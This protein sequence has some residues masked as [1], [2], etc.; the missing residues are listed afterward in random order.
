[1]TGKK[2]IVWGMVLLAFCT[3]KL[4]AQSSD[5]W[6][7][8]PNLFTGTDSEKIAQAL[9]AAENNGGVIRIP[10]RAA[11]A[12]SDR[13]FWLLDEAV[14]LPSDTTLILENCVLKLSD[15][16]RD[17]FIRTA[18]AG[19]GIENPEPVHNIHITGIGSV[20]LIG[21]DHPRSTGDSGKV[22]GQRSYGTDA[23]KE[24]ESQKGDWRNIGILLANVDNF[25]IENL[26]LRQTHCWGISIERGTNG[27]IRGLTFDSSENRTID[28]ATVKTLNQD[29][30]D[31]RKGCRNIVIENIR[32][33]TGDDLVALTAI[34]IDKRPG[35][36]L[37]STEV[38]PTD[39]D[40]DNDI[41]YVTIK[42]VVGYAAGG[43][44]IV[45]LLNASG[46]KIHH[47]VIDTVVDTSPEDVIDRATVRIGDANPS[48]GGVT[49]LGDT[50]GILITNVESRSAQAVLIAGSLTDSIITNVINYNPAVTG[51]G[52]ESGEENVRNVQ[53]APFINAGQN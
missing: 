21:A 42:N 5:G 9:A 6:N 48:W 10:A 35:G 37:E 47:V 26:K 20:E 8:T 40:V 31:L 41:C 12:A 43:H 7:N 44:Q 50:H 29:G 38:M 14:L 15:Q 30:L 28:G 19:L 11:D 17:N 13:N 1:M 23:G 36:R 32:G 45:R 3:A 16:C 18:N 24:G 27:T 51:V 39:P 53:I 4:S 22:L 25:S 49:P 46:I 33:V 34:G 52:F 2:M